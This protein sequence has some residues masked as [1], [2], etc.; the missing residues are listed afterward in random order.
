MPREN[1][2]GVWD[3]APGQSVDRP[4]QAGD[5]GRMTP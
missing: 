1:G 3:L 2:A 5:D 4:H